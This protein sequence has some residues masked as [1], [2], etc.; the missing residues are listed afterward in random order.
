MTAV[1]DET[2]YGE[3]AADEARAREIVA[4]E[5]ELGAAQSRGVRRSRTRDRGA[6]M[7]MVDAGTRSS[8]DRSSRRT[9]LLIGLG[10]LAALVVISVLTR[11][12][13]SF[14]DPLDPRNPAHDGGQ[15]VARVLADNGVDVQVA[16][17][18]ED[19]LGEEVDAGTAVVVTNP[20]EL[21]GSTLKRLRE[22]GKEAGAIVVVGDS[23]VVGGAV[24]HRGRLPRRTAVIAPT[25]TSRWRAGSSYALMTAAGSRPRGASG[26][27]APRCSYDATRC[28]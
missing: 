24:R 21:G 25:A 9:T 17:G 22:H 3:R 5:A 12:T 26:R 13:A 6:A 4:L 2:R 27:T 1:F 18:E 11:D 7:T 8:T 19:L 10:I 28:G 16:R 15:A 20:G 14:T 23:A